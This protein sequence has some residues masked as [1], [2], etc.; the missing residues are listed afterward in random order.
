[1][2]EVLYTGIILI[3]AIIFWKLSHRHDR[4]WSTYILWF[5]V[6]I[7][8]ISGLV[9]DIQHGIFPIRTIGTPALYTLLA[10]PLVWPIGAW[11]GRRRRRNT[12]SD[13][14]TA[15]SASIEADPEIWKGPSAK[16]QT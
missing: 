16:G 13:A 2:Y 12:P 6:A 11:E 14:P 15:P 5:A 4:P 10:V 1:M 9:T 3:A 7:G 8:F